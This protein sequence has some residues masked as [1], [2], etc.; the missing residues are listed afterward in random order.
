MT[1]YLDFTLQRIA[2]ARYFAQGAGSDREPGEQYS[3]QSTCQE[4]KP[5]ALYSVIVETRKQHD[6]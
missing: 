6:Q 1:L 2:V 3:F 4:T 5:I